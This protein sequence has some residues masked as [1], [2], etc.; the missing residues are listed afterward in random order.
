MAKFGAAHENQRTF[1][2][3]KFKWWK[4]IGQTC[5]EGYD[6]EFSTEGSKV[7]RKL[8]DFLYGFR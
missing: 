6:K 1:K 7:V 8:T 2:P 4:I 5:M 3:E